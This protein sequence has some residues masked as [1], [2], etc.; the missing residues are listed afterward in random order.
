[1]NTLLIYFL[2]VNIIIV[3]SFVHINS[4]LVSSTSSN[5]K[6][7]SISDRDILSEVCKTRDVD[8]EA[9]LN[10]INKVL[11]DNSKSNDAKSIIE[12]SWECIFSS[13]P[14]GA[15]NG[16]VVGGFF[17]GYFAI[18]EI[19]N[20]NNGK[21]EVKSSL[22]SFVGSY[23]I[24]KQLTIEYE[25][26]KFIPLNIGI[27]AQDQP[28]RG[29]QAN[30]QFLYINDDIAITKIAPSNACVLLKRVRRR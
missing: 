15:A 19:I 4:K 22:G 27:L 12:G 30:Y 2:L 23:K 13:I 28:L 29:Y 5:F 14:G 20:F 8:R 1:M 26:E 25:L 6:L 11:K 10:L 24:V 17:N 21:I 16:F 3:N 18:E 7:S 9:L